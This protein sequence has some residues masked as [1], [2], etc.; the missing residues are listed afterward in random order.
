MIPK[1]VARVAMAM[2]EGRSFRIE[3]RRQRVVPTKAVSGQDALWRG[4]FAINRVAPMSGFCPPMRFL[5]GRQIDVFEG[6]RARIF[7]KVRGAPQAFALSLTGR[8]PASYIPARAGHISAGK[9]R[10]SGL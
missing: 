7:S 3:H 1:I 2:G 5:D 10:G 9:S 6:C 8:R 4:R